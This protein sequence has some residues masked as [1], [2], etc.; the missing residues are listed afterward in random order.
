MAARRQGR[1]LSVHS[2][3]GQ[4]RT[5]HARRAD[6]TGSE[7]LRGKL[8]Q[9]I[10]EG[11]WSRDGKWLIVRIGSILE[12]QNTDLYAGQLGTG[13]AFRPLLVTTASER[14]IALSPDSRWLAYES[15]ETGPGEVHVRPLPKVDSG[16]GQVS[17]AGGA[18]VRSLSS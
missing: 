12:G 11:I 14:A 18:I 13:S 2:E 16:K 6:G 7:E 3:P 10:H 4:P 8:D 1:V 17:T 15:N 5:L 9:S